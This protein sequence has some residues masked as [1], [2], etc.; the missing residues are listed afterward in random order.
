M[1]VDYNYKNVWT[2]FSGIVIFFIIPLTIVMIK[3]PK[4]ASVI[5]TTILLLIF[6]S[7][8]YMF[9]KSFIRSL[10]KLPAIELTEEFYIDNLNGVKIPWSNVISVG[11]INLGMWSFLSLDLSDNSIFYKQIENPIQSLL[12]RFETLLTGTSMK[13]NIS[14]VDGKNE[15]VFWKVFNFHKQ[16]KNK[17]C[18]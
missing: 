3:S 18:S 16:I 17:S 15:D 2:N 12:F 14:L 5:F 11:T 9:I 10:N 8:I 1:K 13:T 6:G 7:S 4:P